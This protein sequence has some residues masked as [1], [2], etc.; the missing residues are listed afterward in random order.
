MIQ[1]TTLK[2]ILLII[3]TVLL[4]SSCETVKLAGLEQ[5]GFE[6]RDVLVSRIE[7]AR[8]AQLE[9][10][11]QFENALQEFQSVVKFD[12]GELEK[13]YNRLSD[14]YKTS[15]SRAEDV[16]KR[17]NSVDYVAEKLFDEWSEE[18]NQYSNPELKRKSQAQLYE[19]KRQYASLIS[20]MRKAERT[21][22][23]VLTVFNDQVLY[24]KHNLNA[25]AIASLKDELSGI[26]SN[27]ANLIR[28]MNLSIDKAN[29]FI[30][31]MEN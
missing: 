25:R 11:E 16:T 7:K 19:T 2:L 18:L 17:I 9:A 12:G 15:K 13:V 5:L 29:R 1:K 30:K 6:K 21:I 4:V 8:D 22:Q 24:L 23:P 28:E 26:E 27:V 31:D 20:A 3:T 14:E 10:K